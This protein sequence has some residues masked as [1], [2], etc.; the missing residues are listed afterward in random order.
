MRNL[1][2]EGLPNRVSADIYA[3]PIATYQAENKC[4]FMTAFVA[5]T[6]A[7]LVKEPDCTFYVVDLTA[8]EL[9]R[10]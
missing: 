6:G 4:D 5:V 2:S 7:E 1:G 3:E 8:D 9:L 10:S